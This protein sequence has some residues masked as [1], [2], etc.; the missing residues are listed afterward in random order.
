MNVCLCILHTL[1]IQNSGE[2]VLAEVEEGNKMVYRT[3]N[4]HRICRITVT[5]FLINL[6]QLVFIQVGLW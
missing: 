4:L 6:F 3:E 5:S 2:E 1:I